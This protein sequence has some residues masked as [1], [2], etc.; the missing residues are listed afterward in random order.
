MWGKILLEILERS[1]DERNVY[2][3]DARE[4]GGGEEEPESP[5]T[6][7]YVA[8]DF[9]FRTRFNSKFDYRCTTYGDA[10]VNVP[11]SR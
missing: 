5:R 1:N 11:F 6:F 9:Y 2:S 8:G 4:E 7:S 3:K 10:T